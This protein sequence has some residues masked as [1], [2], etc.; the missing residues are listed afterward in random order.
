VGIE[1]AKLEKEP[2]VKNRSYALVLAVLVAL[3]V[4]SAASARV[5]FVH[6]YRLAP[7]KVVKVHAPD[8]RIARHVH[9]DL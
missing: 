7:G 1:P 8:V 9:R 6:S 4:T 3:M 2:P 5:Q